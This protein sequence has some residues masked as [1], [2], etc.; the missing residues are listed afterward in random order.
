MATV[1]TRYGTVHREGPY[2][3]LL[4]AKNAR[5]AYRKSGRGAEIV[6]I[7]DDY[8]VSWWRKRD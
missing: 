6:K 1:R 8:Y 7:R 5:D 2:N 3:S 4:D